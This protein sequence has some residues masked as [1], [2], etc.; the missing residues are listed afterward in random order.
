MIITPFISY[1]PVGIIIF[2]AIDI[3]LSMVLLKYESK[4]I[5]YLENI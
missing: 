3:I 1:I 5:K 2:F 4:I